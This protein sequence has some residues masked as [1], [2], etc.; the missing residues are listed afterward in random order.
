MSYAPGKH[1]GPAFQ[2][3]VDVMKVKV[4][5]RESI[6]RFVESVDSQVRSF[7]LLYVIL[8]LIWDSALVANR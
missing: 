4:P 5:P 3:G 8:R 1:G 2:I 7:R 6:A